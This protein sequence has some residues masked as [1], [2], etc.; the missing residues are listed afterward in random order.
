MK[1]LIVNMRKRGQMGA[2]SRRVCAE[3]EAAVRH[4]ADI[5]EDGFERVHVIQLGYLERWGRV[6]AVTVAPDKPP[7]VPGSRH[8]LAEAQDAVLAFAE[9]ASETPLVIVSSVA[10]CGE[11]AYTD[12]ETGILGLLGNKTRCRGLIQVHNLGWVRHGAARLTGWLPVSHKVVGT[13]VVATYYY[14]PQSTEFRRLQTI[15]S[16]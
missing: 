6:C 13:A 8:T 4:M 5:D 3:V 16:P 12:A 11:T 7:L 1:R 10:L 15:G 9:M 2:Y 14:P